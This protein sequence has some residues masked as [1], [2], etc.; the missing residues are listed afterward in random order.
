MAVIHR[1]IRMGADTAQQLILGG[2]PEDLEEAVILATP[3]Q[4]GVASSLLAAADLV[5]VASTADLAIRA[6]AD[7]AHRGHVL[8]R[9]E[10][11]P[12]PELGSVP[13]K[14]A[15]RL[16]TALLPVNE[17]LTQTADMLASLE[18][19]GDIDTIVMHTPDYAEEAL[20]L[21]NYQGLAGTDVAVLAH[22][23]PTYGAAMSNVPCLGVLAASRSVWPSLRRWLPLVGSLDELV[24][25]S[26]SIG[27]SEHVRLLVLPGS[28]R[29]CAPLPTQNVLGIPAWLSSNGMLPRPNY[30]GILASGTESAPPSTEGFKDWIQAHGWRQRAQ[31]ALP[32]R[33]G[34]LE[35]AMKDLW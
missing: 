18:E 20:R 16:E 31:L 29:G 34:M 2:C 3:D 9:G 19:N 32:W 28:G 14:R 21:M 10:V 27:L 5:V 7:A 22:P 12:I 11:D 6:V 23:E 30:A 26:L 13:A 35:K 17:S 33:W 4:D 1:D 24:V 8:L 15:D 25:W